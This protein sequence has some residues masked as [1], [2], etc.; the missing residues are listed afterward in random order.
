MISQ[1]KEQLTTHPH[2]NL[3]KAVLYFIGNSTKDEELC[4]PS[5]N[6]IP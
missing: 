3:K 5:L 4:L 1:L 2:S 6:W